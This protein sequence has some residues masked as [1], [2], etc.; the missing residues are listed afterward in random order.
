[1]TH[2]TKYKKIKKTEHTKTYDEKTQTNKRDTI[3]NKA[4]YKKEKY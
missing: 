2:I 3:I 4:T 1:M